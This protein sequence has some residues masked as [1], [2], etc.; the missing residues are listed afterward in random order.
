MPDLNDVSHKKAKNRST[1]KERQ[2][3][4]VRTEGRGYEGTS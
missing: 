4:G 1:E 3:E 2:K